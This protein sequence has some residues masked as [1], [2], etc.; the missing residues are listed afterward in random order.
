MGVEV[1]VATHAKAMT[2]SAVFTQHSTLQKWL[3]A[4][5]PFSAQLT[6]WLTAAPYWWLAVMLLVTPPPDLGHPWM[7]TCGMLAVALASTFF[8]GVVCFS[9]GSWMPV[10]MGGPSLLYLLD[11]TLAQ[12]YVCALALNLGV[13]RMAV[14][15]ALTISILCMNCCVKKYVPPG[16]YAL[17]H[18]LCHVCSASVMYS[19]LN[20]DGTAVDH[21]LQETASRSGDICAWPSNRR[22]L[23]WVDRINSAR[24][25][26]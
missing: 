4:A 25:V 20:T 6:F 19:L 10:G 5:L 18:G 3:G 13:G 2:N 12:G 14:L 22:Q 15:S 17:L 26:H 1:D 21:L 9:T 11:L 8:R 23:K 7:H 16:W 24:C